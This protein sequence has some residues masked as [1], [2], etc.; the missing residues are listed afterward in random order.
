MMTG[1]HPMAHLFVLWI[2][3]TAA[4]H[5][6][7][8]YCLGRPW[9]QRE[10]G[11]VGLA[12]KRKLRSQRTSHAMSSQQQHVHE[13]QEVEGVSQ[14]F[15]SSCRLWLM[16]C[17][18]TSM[19]EE[20]IG[21]EERI[22]L[23]AAARQR[24][25]EADAR[26]K[27]LLQGGAPATV[28]DDER[29]ALVFARLAA[30]FNETVRPV[31]AWVA[32]EQGE[33]EAMLEAFVS[34]LCEKYDDVPAP[35]RASLWHVSSYEVKPVVETSANRVAYRFCKAYRRVGHGSASVRDAVRDEC[36]EGL[37]KKA[38]A[39]FCR[40][41]DLNETTKR[42]GPLRSL[43]R[44]QVESLGGSAWIADAVSQ[45]QCAT[46]FV[47]D[48]TFLGAD[49]MPWIVN[50]AGSFAEP[51]LVSLAA[52]FF[53]EMRRTDPK[54]TCTRRTPKTVSEAMDAYALTTVTFSDD[55]AFLP[56]PRGIRPLFKADTIIPNGTLV[57]VPYDSVINGGHG[58]YRLGPGTERGAEPRTLR[59]EEILSLKRLIYEGVKLDNCLE[60]RRESQLKYVMRARQ[61]FSSFWS[62]TLSGDDDIKH[63]LLLEVW[64][65]HDRNV[66]RQAEG[67]RPR[68]LPSPEAWYWMLVWCE[69][70][71]VDWTTWDVYS[72]LPSI[73]P[74]E[75]L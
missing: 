65:L 62:F 17:V 24:V 69:A 43:R 74:C 56:N 2:G 25:T 58:P 20:G 57:E 1:R 28:G 41:L 3:V 70:N 13:D 46:F 16:S 38:A 21:T 72:R 10:P 52:D 67:P 23:R 39:I 34:H 4:L 37:T 30:W 9:R 15:L 63:I 49:A 31:E 36:V 8:P 5:A 44:A 7:T 40:W 26:L 64:H 47:E 48:E 60:D 50:H 6:T 42:E 61:R 71:N 75:P 11:Y 35:L 32:P 55:E 66:V 59:V 68:T 14:A 27:M 51:H 54:Y 18:A 29:R 19:G 73:R 22:D 33:P 12:V 53:V 45:S